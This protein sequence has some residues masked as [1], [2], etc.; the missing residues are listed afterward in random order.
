MVTNNTIKVEIQCISYLR[1][2]VM[3]LMHGT[4]GNIDGTGCSRNHACQLPYVEHVAY[5]QTDAMLN[6]TRC[7]GERNSKF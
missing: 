6:V 7:D 1:F 5:F 2:W 3:H 4:A